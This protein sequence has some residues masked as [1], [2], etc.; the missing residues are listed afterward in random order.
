MYTSSNTTILYFI[1]YILLIKYKII[2]FDEVY[3]LFNFNIILKHNGM[4]Y[5]KIIGF[6]LGN[7]YLF[8]LQ[9][10]AQAETETNVCILCYTAANN[11]FK[12]ICLTFSTLRGHR[13]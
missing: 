6:F 9:L 10:K 3:I 7:Y 5:I 2:V 13:L 11:N 4:S 1:T 8:I 12:L